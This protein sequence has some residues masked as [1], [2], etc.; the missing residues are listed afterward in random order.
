[1]K[2]A[3][4]KESPRQTA[5][6]PAISS[7]TSQ[8]LE[9]WKESVQPRVF[10]HRHPNTVRRFLL[11]SVQYRI[12]SVGTRAAF[13]GPLNQFILPSSDL[14]LISKGHL[15]RSSLSNKTYYDH[16]TCWFILN[17]Q[18]AFR[19]ENSEKFKAQTLEMS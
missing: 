3:R 18:E 14:K 9:L 10:C 17:L 4:K 16:F 11:N 19:A 6:L 5:D 15:L 8:P 2:K 13:P 1:M 12:C 7:W